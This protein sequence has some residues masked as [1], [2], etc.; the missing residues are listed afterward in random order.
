MLQGGILQYFR[1]SLSYHFPIRPLFCLFGSG[2]LRQ[3]LLF[4]LFSIFEA[5]FL[6]RVKPD[7]T[8]VR[9]NTENFTHVIVLYMYFGMLFFLP[10]D[11]G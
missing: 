11:L 8:E 6:W 10:N 5:N 2:P 9:N 1:P 3:V 7:N 4:A